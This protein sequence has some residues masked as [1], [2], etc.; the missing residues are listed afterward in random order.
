MKLCLVSTSP[1]E[2]DG[3][4]LRDDHYRLLPVARL[5]ASWLRSTV[6][7]C[8][9]YR[10]VFDGNRLSDSVAVEGRALAVDGMGVSVVDLPYAERAEAML[11]YPVSTEREPPASDE[12]RTALDHLASRGF[13]R[14][15]R[16]RYGVTRALLMEA[17]RRGVVT[18]ATG[19]DGLWGMKDGLVTALDGYAAAT[20]SV[21][22]HPCSRAVLGEE[23]AR[24]VTELGHAG[25]DLII[26][27]ANGARGAGVSVVLAHEPRRPLLP[28]SGTWVVQELLPQPLLFAGH[29]AD[30]R[31]YALIDTAGRS[32][33]YRP[34]LVLVHRAPAPYRR[35]QIEAEI[36]NTAY[37]RR[38]GLPIATCPLTLCD[39][40]PEAL[41]ATLTPRLDELVAGFLDAYFWR[42]KPGPRRV[43]LWGLDVFAGVVGA[44][45]VDVRLYL[46]EANVQP[47]LLPHSPLCEPYINAM[48]CRDYLPAVCRAVGDKGARRVM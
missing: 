41:R 44:T 37:S 38:L 35:G 27:P 4:Q 32:L 30:L 9:W 7:V 8:P 12:E 25:L 17:A 2:I 19:V 13:L 33:S 16:T 28:A 5:Y 15:S 31:C 21:V 26:K 10:L 3:K 47:A 39:D 11:F 23:L 36:T 40:V 43:M 14:G 6:L 22:P 29:K 1:R 34:E 42:A 46:L 20:G 18:N 45:G 48:L 24:T